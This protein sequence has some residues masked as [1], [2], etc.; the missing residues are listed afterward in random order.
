[1]AGRARLLIRAGA[2]TLLY[3]LA[4]CSAQPVGSRPTV[5]PDIRVTPAPTQNVRATATAFA[6]QIVPT[7]TPVG[8]Y[9][10]KAGDTLST[11]ATTFETT[12]DELMALNNLSD[13]NL[14]EIGQE[15]RIPTL[16]PSVEPLPGGVPPETTEQP[17]APPAEQAPPAEAPPAAT[18][19][20]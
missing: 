15:L 4:A 7:P 11:I 6:Q 17:P 13:P 19:A 16:L 3:A 14:I 8:Q 10:V 12:V 2:L 1:M 5:A 18:A 20:Q 9:I